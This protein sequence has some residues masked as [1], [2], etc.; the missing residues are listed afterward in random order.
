M[1]RVIYESVAAP[2]STMPL[3]GAFAG[4]ALLLGA[5]GIYGLISYSVVQRT[6]EIGV[7]MALG[8]TK[9]E[10]MKVIFSRGSRLALVGIAVG[11]AGALALTRLMASLLY[12]VNPRDP[13]TLVV[14]AIVVATVAVVATS[15]PSL[16][17]TKVDPTVALRSE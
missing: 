13:L 2:R 16:R 8:A 12:G 1:D 10:V 5:I 17:A 3:F 9:T 11:L 4:L 7:R 14:V 15:I 6:H